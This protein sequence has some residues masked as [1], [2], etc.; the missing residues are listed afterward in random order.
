NGYR[1]KWLKHFCSRDSFN[2][3]RLILCL[4]SNTYFTV[5]Q[6]VFLINS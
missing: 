5:A 1:G 3:V 4:T 6:H 2:G